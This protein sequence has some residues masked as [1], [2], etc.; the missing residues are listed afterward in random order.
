MEVNQW[1]EKSYKLPAF[2][3]EAVKAETIKNPNWI[4]FGA[5]NIFRAFLANVNQ[6]NLNEK[7]AQKGIVVAE[8]FDYEIIEKMNKPHDN[9]SLLV[10][11]KSTGEV[12]KTVVAS[13]MESLTVDPDNSSDWKRLK[14][15]FVNPSLQIVSFTITEKGYNL[16]DNKGSYYPA[17]QA[18]FEAGPENTQSYIGK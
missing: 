4:H 17:V 7:S 5:G 9:L 15:I 2:D 8:G 14:E 12:E 10:T 6:N 3:Y 1:N 11:L 18:D 13:V 16:K